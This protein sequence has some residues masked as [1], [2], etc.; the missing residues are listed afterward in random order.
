MEAKKI[1]EKSRRFSRFSTNMKA[2][3]LLEL[4]KDWKE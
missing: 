2:Q 4:D 1:E 3:Y